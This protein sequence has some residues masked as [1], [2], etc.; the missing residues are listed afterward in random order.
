VLDRGLP[1]LPQALHWMGQLLEALAHLH[2]RGLV[3]RDVKPANLLLASDGS[4][5]LAD[6]GI[7]RRRGDHLVQ[8][9]S[10]TPN[11]MA[12]E[13]MRGGAADPRS[14]LYAAGVV[15]YELLTGSRPYLGTAFEVMQQ[16]LAGRHAPPSRRHPP[17]GERYDAILGAALAPDPRHRYADARQF[18]SDLQA[19]A[20]AE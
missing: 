10:G 18:H 8:D 6:F 14:D 2:Q 4:L 9:S 19:A 17:L 16:A 15:L 13:Q 20:L 5:K 1:P 3:H 7:A 11:Y 12:P